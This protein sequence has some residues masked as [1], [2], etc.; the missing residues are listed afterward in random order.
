MGRTIFVA[1]HG[2]TEWNRIGR[3][4]GVTDVPLSDV[5]RAQARELGRR[6][7]GRGIGRL[8]TSH[9]SRARETA[10]IVAVSLELAVPA[11]DPRLRERGYG[12]FE[13]LTGDE[14][15]ALHPEAWQR[16]L[17][18]RRQT[19]PDAESQPEIVARMTAAMREIAA[20]PTSVAVAVAL[21]IAAGADTDVDADAGV[22][23]DALDPAPAVAGSEAV[24]VISHGGAL[25][26]FLHATF[27]VAPPPIGNGSVFRLAFDGD[28]FVSFDPE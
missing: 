6:L 12:R 21:A 20:A 10:E 4:Q 9:L 11:L 19:P 7:A 24:L 27:G 25:R 8:Y 26:S 13:G 17:A 16:Y 2:E 14:C 22:A 28:R 5:G 15:G 23:A 1:R 3:W 18:D